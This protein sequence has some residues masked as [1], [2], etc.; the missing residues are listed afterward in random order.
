MERGAIPLHAATRLSIMAA[1]TVGLG[2]GVWWCAASFGWRSPLFAALANWCVVAY[3]AVTS[4]A[5]HWK[6]PSGVHRLHAWETDGSV[7][8]RLGVG[9]FGGLVRR[10]PLRLLS[11]TLFVRGRRDRLTAVL[12]GT[13][14]AEAAHWW[15]AVLAFPLAVFA[16]AQ[17]S[18]VS[19]AWLFFFNVV[20]NV[21]PALLQR[22]TRTRL[23][24]V[25]SGGTV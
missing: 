13:C 22:L 23:L 25:L 11:P 16:I 19:S 18:W 10:T 1:A 9:C 15:A 6:L 17:H 12:A 3:V 14:R 4:A 5:V 21:Y 20:F 2:V 24:A 8:R 7:Y